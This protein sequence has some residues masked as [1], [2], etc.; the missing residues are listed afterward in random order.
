MPHAPFLFDKEY[1]SERNQSQSQYTKRRALVVNISGDHLA[2]TLLSQIQA[3][4]ITSG[5][6]KEPDTILNIWFKHAHSYIQNPLD[7]VIWVSGLLNLAEGPRQRNDNADLLLGS[8]CSPALDQKTDAHHMRRRFIKH[9]LI[10]KPLF[11]FKRAVGESISACG[12]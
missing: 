1:P 4:P 2:E 12:T 6:G 3:M 10:S 11:G 7:N 5:D 8:V 9:S